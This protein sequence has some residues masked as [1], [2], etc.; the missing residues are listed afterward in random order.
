MTNAGKMNLSSAANQQQGTHK[1]TKLGITR[2]LMVIALCSILLTLVNRSARLFEATSE[3]AAI[4]TTTTT[5]N[6]NVASKTV[7][8]APFQKPFIL[9]NL[10]ESIVQA[11]F[12]FDAT[13]KELYGESFFPTIFH[14]VEEVFGLNGTSRDRFQRRILIKLCKSLSFNSSVEDNTFMWVTG[15]NSNAAAHGN[16]FNQSYTAT[17]EHYASK[18]F[19]A[20]GLDFVAK[21]YAIGTY[22][23][24]LELAV[25]MDSVYGQNFDLFMWDFSLTDDRSSFN[26]DLMLNRIVTG[27]TAWPAS[28]ALPVVLVLDQTKTRRISV[29]R[30]TERGLGAISMNPALVLDDLKEKLPDA[31]FVDQGNLTEYLANFLCK[32]ALERN[33]A[34]GANKFQ[35]QSCTNVKG[36]TSWH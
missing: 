14:R 9:Q 26:L 24:G 22:P 31:V 4:P 35:T 8:R 10:R 13:M 16:L 32:G 25:C 1:K 11:R 5:K 18:A 17:V 21:N 7:D 27:S 12:E 34:C 36:K 20:V 29:Q 28:S 30:A 33:F 3:S 23:S 2:V 6:K 19:Q 15:G